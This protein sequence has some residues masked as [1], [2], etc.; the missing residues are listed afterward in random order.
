[1]LSGVITT[2]STMHSDAMAANST[3][4]SESQLMS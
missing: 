3:Y 1:M 2:N 4:S